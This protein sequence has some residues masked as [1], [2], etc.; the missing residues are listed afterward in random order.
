M[1]AQTATL[2]S[3]LERANALIAALT[4]SLEIVKAQVTALAEAVE[5]KATNHDLNTKID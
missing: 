5:L 3:S 1:R 2:S 4:S